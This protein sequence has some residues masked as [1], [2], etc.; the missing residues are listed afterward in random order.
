MGVYDIT[1]NA[2]A[3]GGAFIS[4]KDFGAKG[5]G[6]TN[7]SSAIQRAFDS[8]RTTGGTIYF[9]EGTYKLETAVQFYSNTVL[10][11]E[12]GAVLTQGA[13]IN[14]LLRS[15]CDPTWTE[16]NGTHDV[17]I[18]GATFDGGDYTTNNTLVGVAHARNI[19][20]I[21][22]AFIN[23]YGAWHDL[24]IN[25][26]SNVKVINCVFEGA[27]KNSDRGELIQLDS[28]YDSSAYPWNINSD[29][30]VCEEIEISGC[31]FSDSMASAIGQHSS[32][33]HNFVKIHD[34]HF[35]D[36]TASRG[37]ICLTGAINVDIYN[38]SFDTCATGIGAGDT[39]WF[40]HGNRFVDVTTA[41]NSNYIVAHNNMINGTY[42]E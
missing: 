34:N 29:N 26:S 19:T 27:R 25:S 40:A 5:D 32:S 31:E 39:T 41:I 13:A 12:M 9:P 23:A 37:T 22:C 8:V 35:S 36:I 24:E 28:A 14:N 3:S 21:N 18:C 6:A 11:F 10:L 16:Y 7:D 30:T 17:I 38:N 42:T 33:V 2:L 1:G 20:L 4:V 15:F